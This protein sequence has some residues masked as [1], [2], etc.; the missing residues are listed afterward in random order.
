MRVHLDAIR[1]RNALT[2]RD[3]RSPLTEDC[4]ELPVLGE[5]LAESVEPLGHNLVR[6]KSK[7]LCAD[8]GL[9]ARQDP[10]I[11]TGLD[12][13]RSICGFSAACL[14]VEDRAAYELRG[15]RR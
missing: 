8:V 7:R 11:A 4:A 9:D 12:A 13:R 15:T 10:L 14:V 3:D 1:R 6:S 5:T 2:D